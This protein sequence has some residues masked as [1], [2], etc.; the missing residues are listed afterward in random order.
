MYPRIYH[1]WLVL[2]I[3][4][5]VM[6]SYECKTFKSTRFPNGTIAC[7]TDS[8]TKTSPLN[9]IHSCGECS[10]YC[11][12]YGM[13]CTWLCSQD[14]DCTNYNYREDLGMC[15]IFHYTQ[16]NVSFIPGCYNFQVC[17]KCNFI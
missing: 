15:E 10:E 4:L 6:K 17:S 8:P 16:R 13:Q 9:Q 11:K 3:W 1:C 14:D 2:N 12:V 7:A 5:L